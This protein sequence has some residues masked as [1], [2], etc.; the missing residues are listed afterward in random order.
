MKLKILII[1]LITV[2]LYTCELLHQES[3]TDGDDFTG[4]T[5]ITFKTGRI[6]GWCGGADSLVIQQSKMF[7]QK[8]DFCNDTVITDVFETDKHFW[9]KLTDVFDYETFNSVKHTSCAVCADGCDTWIQIE[10]DTQSHYIQY[11]S[12]QYD[13]VMPVKNIF[14][15]IVPGDIETVLSNLLKNY[16]F[17]PV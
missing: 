9:S 17:N 10:K 12:Y 8:K 14:D 7:Y 5:L 6:C 11:I 4:D 1:V 2:L 13:D 15:V 16:Q 3:S